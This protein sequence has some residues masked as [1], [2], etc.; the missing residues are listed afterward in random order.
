M[1]EPK[2]GRIIP[3]S[4]GMKELSVSHENFVLVRLSKLQGVEY[5]FTL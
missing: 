4:G 1:L 2:E 5:K 3:R